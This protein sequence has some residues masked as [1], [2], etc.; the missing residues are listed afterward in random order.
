MLSALCAPG[1]PVGLVG[2]RHCFRGLMM[3]L[4]PGL[5]L[6]DVSSGSTHDS[7]TPASPWRG[8]SSAPLPY[9]SQ[10]CSSEYISCR[11]V[12]PYTLTGANMASETWYQQLQR[13]QIPG[14]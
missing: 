5:D 3:S 1:K 6:N 12:R 7:F 14:A 13:A 8:L 9:S 4:N 10:G 2:W 11:K